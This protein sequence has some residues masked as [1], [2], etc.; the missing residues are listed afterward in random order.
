EERVRGGTGGVGGKGGGGGGEEA[1]E[2]AVGE[3]P[4]SV[5]AGLAYEDARHFEAAPGVA[6]VA[7]RVEEHAERDPEGGLDFVV[8]R[9]QQRTGGEAVDARREHERAA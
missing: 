5:A 9:D 1:V 3:A 8:L 7:G 2:G 6:Y 4:D